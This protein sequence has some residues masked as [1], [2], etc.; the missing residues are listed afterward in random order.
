MDVCKN[1]YIWLSDEL[2]AE[3]VQVFT[4]KESMQMLEVFI[5]HVLEYCG[6]NVFFQQVI[7]VLD[8]FV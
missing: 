5:N 8:K 6:L 1:L 4:V 7:Q 3:V 2:G